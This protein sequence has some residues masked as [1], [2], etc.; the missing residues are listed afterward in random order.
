MIGQ[1]SWRHNQFDKINLIVNEGKGAFAFGPL[2]Q[3]PTP[4]GAHMILSI[5]GANLVYLFSNIEQ[6]LH[7]I[8]KILL[9]VIVIIKLQ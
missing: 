2:F 4:F 8:I 1:N 7:M 6:F 9:I 3:P 5:F